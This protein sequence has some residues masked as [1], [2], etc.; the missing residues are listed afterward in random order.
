MPIFIVEES[1]PTYV[2]WRAEVE[3][4]TEEE[5]ME[6]FIEGDYDGEEE[7]PLWN[8]AIESL[9]VL[10]SAKLREEKQS[11]E[12]GAVQKEKE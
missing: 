9:P 1:V 11:S 12:C 7:G 6:K 3:A 10:R 5:A 4:E 2:T 8:D